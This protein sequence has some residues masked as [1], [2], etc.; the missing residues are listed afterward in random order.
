VAVV[1]VAVLGLASGVVIWLAVL[2]LY[3][4]QQHTNLVLCETIHVVYR[5][6]VLIARDL[7]LKLPPRPPSC[8][9]R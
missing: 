2:D 9:V 8:S 3:D 6:Q 4:R 5:H 1:I 7:H